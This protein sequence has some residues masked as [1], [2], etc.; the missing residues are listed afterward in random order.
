MAIARKVHT[1]T[2]GEGAQAILTIPVDGRGRPKRPTS[3]A[4][5]IVDL[6]YVVDSADRVIQTSTAGVVDT[7]DTTTTAAAGIGQAEMRKVALTSAAGVAA[8][9]RYLLTDLTTGLA[10]LVE[11]ESVVG[12]TVYL[13]VP[14]A[15]T[16]A[17]GSTFRG[18]EVSAT[19]PSAEAADEARLDDGGGPYMVQWTWVGVD[20]T[21]QDELCYVRRRPDDLWL[22]TLDECDQV[23]VTLRAELSNTAGGM[24]PRLFLRQAHE[25]LRTQLE[26]V[27]LDPAAYF[28]HRVAREY[29]KRRWAFMGRMHLAQDEASPNKIKADMHRFEARDLIGTILLPGGH[30]RPTVITSQREDDD[31]ADAAE[32]RSKFFTRA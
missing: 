11:V 32:G 15:A 8:Q 16:Y 9:H 10:D 23:D 20:P 3:G 7:V 22:V 31:V 1:V 6:R 18:A 28:G 19:F 25:D 2:F 27:A 26:A 5:V 14:L 17:T 21:S 24:A 29:V 4:Y 13:S 12:S 30:P